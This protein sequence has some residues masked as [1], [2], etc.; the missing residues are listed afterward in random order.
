[1]VA[2]NKIDLPDADPEKSEAAPDRAQ[3]GPEDFGGDVICVNVSAKTGEG[4]DTAARDARASG[5]GARAESG[6]RTRRG[7]GVVLEARLDKG[8]GPM[9]TLLVQDGTLRP[10]DV[11]VVDTEIRSGARNGGRQRAIASRRPGPSDPRSRCSRTLRWCRRQE[12][13][14]PRGGE[15]SRCQA[16]HL[17]SRGSGALEVPPRRLPRLTLE[18]FFAQCRGRGARRSSA[19]VLKADVQGTCRGRA[20]L[21]GEALHRRGQAAR[22]LSSGVGC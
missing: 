14:L 11:I 3:P 4:L 8:R 13:P 15:R 9:A 7:K 12:R 10:G 22:M 21:P 6:S 18:E 19:V 2:I 17:A 16:D 1:M 20:R 5:R